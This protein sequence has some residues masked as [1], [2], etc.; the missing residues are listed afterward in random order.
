MTSTVAATPLMMPRRKPVA[1]PSAEVVYTTA[2]GQAPRGTYAEE[3]PQVRVVDSYYGAYCFVCRRVTEHAGEHDA[4]VEAGLASYDRDGSVLRTERW[5]ADK[6]R[7]IFEAEYAA[8][9]ARI[10]GTL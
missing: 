4:L 10:E 7:E 5:D 8:Y 2:T 6:A 9:V 1:A 3:A